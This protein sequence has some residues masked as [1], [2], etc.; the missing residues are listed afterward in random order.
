[1]ESLGHTLGLMSAIFYIID[2]FYFKIMHMCVFVC[3]CEHVCEL[4]RRPE[5]WAWNWRYRWLWAACRGC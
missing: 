2:L 3:R 1:M 5:V 4:L